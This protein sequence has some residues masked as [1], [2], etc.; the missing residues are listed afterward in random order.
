MQH[1]VAKAVAQNVDDF[2][3]FP[4]AEP[5][6]VLAVNSCSIHARIPV[7]SK[8]WTEIVA[9]RSKSPSNAAHTDRQQ[10][11]AALHVS[12]LR[13]AGIHLLTA[14]CVRSVNSQRFATFRAMLRR[15]NMGADSLS[16]AS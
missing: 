12:T 9:P 11:G 13:R 6:Q 10:T 16:P 14:P 3:G 5:S 7:P 8:V 15:V 1:G 4:S 2:P